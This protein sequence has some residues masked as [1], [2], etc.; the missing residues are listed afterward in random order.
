MVGA[1]EPAGESTISAHCAGPGDKN[2]SSLNLVLVNGIWSD[3]RLL[4]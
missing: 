3:M 2:G 4:P 1:V